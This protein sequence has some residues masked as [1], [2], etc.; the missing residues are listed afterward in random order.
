MKIGIN[1]LFFQYPATG[2][3]QYMM[4]LL[5]AL[6][7]IDK[8]NECQRNSALRRRMRISGVSRWLLRFLLELLLITLVRGET[9][10]WQRHPRK[11]L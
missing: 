7:E 9:S 6:S 3:G 1:A 4:H 8:E 10:V 11:F 2:S 5:H